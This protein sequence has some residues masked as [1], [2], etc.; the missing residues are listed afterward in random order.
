MVEANKVA[1]R[2]L[3]RAKAREHIK[4]QLAYRQQC[5]RDAR[6]RYVV[7]P[8]TA[9]AK[10]I[11][12][13][14][15]EL[16]SPSNHW[17][18]GFYKRHAGTVSEKPVQT[19][20]VA[21]IAS[22]NKANLAEDLKILGRQ[23][24]E[25]DIAIMHKEEDGTFRYIIDPIGDAEAGRS[26]GYVA[27]AK[28]I[29]VDEKGQHCWYNH[30]EGDFKFRKVAVGKG[31]KALEPIVEN[32]EMFTYVPWADANGN[33]QFAQVSDPHPPRVRAHTH[34]HASQI[35][36]CAGHLWRVT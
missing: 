35:P 19:K 33:V 28:V 14:R 18:R 9:H 10:A 6:H 20:D 23:C 29:Q 11:V 8:L 16:Q 24:A 36:F 30:S 1:G 21:R 31:Q 4:E 26:D 13:D 7:K 34:T 32:R 27:R 15:G 12:A 5:N 17:F 22:L 25:P 2:G 3:S